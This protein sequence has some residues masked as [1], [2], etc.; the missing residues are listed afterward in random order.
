MNWKVAPNRIKSASTLQDL[1]SE[2]KKKTEEI[3]VISNKTSWRNKFL[4]RLDEMSIDGFTVTE[5]AQELGMTY[6]QVAS[7]AARYDISFYKRKSR[8]A[9]KRIN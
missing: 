6:S 5:A 9:K 3:E 8:R 1:I 7:F 2:R 4:A